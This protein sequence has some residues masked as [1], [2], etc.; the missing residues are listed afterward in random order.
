LEGKKEELISWIRHHV[1]QRN[2]APS[3]FVV[4]SCVE[5]HWQDIE[6]ISND[7]IKIARSHS[8]SLNNITEKVKAFNDYSIIIEEY[9]QAR[10]TYF[11]ENYATKVFGV[12]SLLCEV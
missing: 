3:L 5:Y 10:V 7:R 8:V 9:F 2:G 11:L 4:L 1:E 6:K 12:P